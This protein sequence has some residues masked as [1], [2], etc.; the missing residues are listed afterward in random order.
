V[1]LEILNISLLSMLPRCILVAFTGE[2]REC[3]V[4]S[5]KPG[6]MGWMFVVVSLLKKEEGEAKRVK[7][8]SHQ[9][10]DSK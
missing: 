5:V 3:K 1:I 8:I 9:H 6:G 10:C 2:I 7:E 4:I